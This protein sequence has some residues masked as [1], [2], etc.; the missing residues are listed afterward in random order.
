[1]HPRGKRGAAAVGA[2]ASIITGVH[3]GHR[4]ALRWLGYVHIRLSWVKPLGM[5]R[6]ARVP[7]ICPKSADRRTSCPN[8]T[9]AGKF[10]VCWQIAR[11]FGERVDDRAMWSRSR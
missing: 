5:D 1:M 10:I 11:W 9:L 3:Q 8:C 2:A 4:G 7:L 6:R